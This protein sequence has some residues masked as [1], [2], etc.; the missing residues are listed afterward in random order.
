MKET[1]AGFRAGFVPITGLPNAGK[2]TLLNALCGMRLSIISEK[3]QTTRNSIMGIL[4][5]EDF[6][7][8]FVDTPGFLKSRNLFEKSMENSI[9]RAASED[10]DLCLLMAEPGL[11]PE[12]KIPLFEPL[13][14]AACPIYLVIN[15][16]DKETSAA[17]ADAAAAFYSA[18]LPIKQVLHISALTGGGVK[19]LRAAIKAALPE[20]PAYYPQDQLTDRWEKFYAAEIIREQIFKL[21]S[22]EIPYAAAVEIEVFRESEGRDT[23]ILA[24]IHVARATQKP[25]IIGKAGRTIGALREKSHKA[26]VAFLGRRIELHLT[27]KVT[28]GWQ[29]DLSFLRELGF[30]DKK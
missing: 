19:E 20:H 14:R 26:L 5:A 7:A 27:V 11:P 29:D 21:Y 30:Y 2:S 17:R 22:Q 4:N 15:K 9:R 25:I 23:Q 13:K 16:L 18:L 24:A 6:Q 12:D 10:G 8:V 28:P 3:P 1:P